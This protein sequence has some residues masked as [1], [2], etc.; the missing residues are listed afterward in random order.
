MSKKSLLEEGTVRRFM[1]LAGTQVLASDF[2][3][4]T[5]EGEEGDDK[6]TPP[7]AW[8]KD[9][10]CKDANGKAVHND[11]CPAK[12]EELDE[13][14]YIDED[15]V[16]NEVFHRVKNR[17]IQEKRTDDMASVLAERIARRMNKRR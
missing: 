11:R 8:S 9:G 3:T 4:E 2:L 14:N 13:I 6:P 5:T 15:A 17:L 10:F 12:K 1:K 16:M 7:F